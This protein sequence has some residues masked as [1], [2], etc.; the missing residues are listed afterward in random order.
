[1]TTL[2][3]ISWQVS[4]K[5][6]RADPALSYSTLAKYEREGFN[7]LSTLFEHVS[8]PS[9][10]LGSMV[11]TLIT[12]SREE[13]NQLFYIVDFNSLGEKETQVAKQ[14]FSE[15][16]NTYNSINDI[17]YD[18]VLQK[19]IF[20]NFYPNWRDDTRVRVLRERCAEYYS[21][22]HYAE[23]KTIV[24]TDTYN[25]ALAMV[26]ALKTSPVTQGYFANNEE[27]NPIQRYYQLKFKH[28]IENVDYR[29]MADLIICDYENKIV[30]PLDLKT[31][32]HHEWDFQ[33]SFLQ[34]SYMIQARLYWR[35]IRT[36][37]NQDDYFK[38]FTLTN[39]KFVVINKD[40]LIPFVW[41]FPYTDFIGDLEDSK[42]NIYRDPFTI[43]K[44]L[45]YYLQEHPRTP[46]GVNKY[47]TNIITCLSP[48]YEK[49]SPSKTANE[50]LYS[51]DNSDAD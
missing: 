39:Y 11:D 19:A 25:K 44:E 15:Y 40:S 21:L 31:S 22:L 9:L 8:T 10:T 3:D 46:V 49:D 1:M 37:M 51:A 33:D 20:I 6:Y 4:E 28:S 30:Y 13:F 36:T 50:D 17:P 16:G 42:G 35:L 24:D 47:G 48:V 2:Y 23:N 29:C 41:E 43:G 7:K 14:L 5:E 38:D 34:W 18:D 26:E 27:G 32:G 45:K 12:G